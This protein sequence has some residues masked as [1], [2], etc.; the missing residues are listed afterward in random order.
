MVYS[1]T[2]STNILESLGVLSSFNIAESIWKKYEQFAVSKII[3]STIRL[4]GSL[5]Y[6][7]DVTPSQADKELTAISPLMPVLTKLRTAIEPID[8]HEYRDFKHAAINFFDTVDLLYANLQEI[9]DVHYSYKLSKPVL[10]R[11]W[12][13]KE[14]EHWDNY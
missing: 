13:S 10:A 14:D 7:K 1:M 2:N 5:F 12:D 6:L 8:E 9:A 3:D 4:R 11:D